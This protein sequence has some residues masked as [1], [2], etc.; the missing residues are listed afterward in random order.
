MITPFSLGVLAGLSFAD[1]ARLANTAAGV[2]VSKVGTAVVYPEEISRAF[3]KK[4][5]PGDARFCASRNWIW[6]CGGSAVEA[7]MF[8]Y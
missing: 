2:V 6:R 3:E 8:I 5:L 7:S 1:A 4:S